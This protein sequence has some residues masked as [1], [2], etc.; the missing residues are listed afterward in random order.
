MKEAPKN[1]EPKATG[2]QGD[3]DQYNDYIK[4]LYKV[5]NKDAKKPLPTDRERPS[6]RAQWPVRKEKILSDKAEH[7]GSMLE[8]ASEFATPKGSQYSKA[9]DESS[10]EE[11]SESSEDVYDNTVLRDSQRELEAESL[12]ETQRSDDEDQNEEDLE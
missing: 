11:S 4:E 7:D 1:E 3:S 9:D 2:E 10:E 8:D 6:K 12:V 5:I